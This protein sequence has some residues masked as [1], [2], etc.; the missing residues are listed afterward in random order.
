MAPVPLAKWGTRHLKFNELVI[1][2]DKFT[3][4]K[5]FHKITF[6]FLLSLHGN[7]FWYICSFSSAPP[8]SIR[9]MFDSVTK[10]NLSQF[11][12]IEITVFLNIELSK[13]TYLWLTFHSAENFEG[14]ESVIYVNARYNFLFRKGIFCEDNKNV[15]SLVPDCPSFGEGKITKI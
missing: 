14:S 2:Y 9:F 3:S 12:G 11:I 5:R 7:P 10:T 8:A 1:L 4:P 13:H 15:G 6:V